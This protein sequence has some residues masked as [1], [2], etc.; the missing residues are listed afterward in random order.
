MKKKPAKLDML[1][2]AKGICHRCEWRVQFIEIGHAPCCECGQITTSKIGCYMYKPVSSVVLAVDKG[3]KRSVALPAFMRGKSHG[4]GI[5]RC[6]QVMIGSEKEY[7]IVP[8]PLLYKK[9]K[10]PK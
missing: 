2:L 8:K 5:A 9:D 1:P 3:E 7:V 6:I 4:I 10:L